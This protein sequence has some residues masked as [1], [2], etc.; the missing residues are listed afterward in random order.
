MKVFLNSF[1]LTGQTLVDFIKITDGFGYPTC[2]R[3]HSP[4]CR[5]KTIF[6]GGPV[7]TCF[8]RYCHPTQVT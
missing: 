8:D 7:G 5:G 1:H 3:A 6:R 2:N 4:T